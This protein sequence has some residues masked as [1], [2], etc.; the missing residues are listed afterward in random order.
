MTTILFYYNS[1]TSEKWYGVNTTIGKCFSKKHQGLKKK[2][3]KTFRNNICKTSH[4]LNF[5]L[6]LFLRQYSTLGEFLTPTHICTIFLCMHNIYSQ[7]YAQYI[8]I[9]N[10]AILFFFNLDISWLDANSSK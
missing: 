6:D 1:T 9:L 5:L 10:Y 3:V 8:R 2:I 4:Y 7:S